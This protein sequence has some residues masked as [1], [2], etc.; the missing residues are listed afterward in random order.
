[1]RIKVTIAMCFVFCLFSFWGADWFG[2]LSYFIWAKSGGIEHVPME[3]F[4]LWLVDKVCTDYLQFRMIVWG[5]ALG[6]F[7]FTLKRLQLNLGVALFFFCSIYLITFSYARASLAMSLLFAGY[8]LLW[9]HN[10][11]AALKNR[12]IGLSLIGLS[13]FCHKSSVLGITAVVAAIIVKKWGRN[14]VILVLLAFPL[15]VF[16]M[17]FFL[18]DMFCRL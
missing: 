10:K 1:M 4:Y 16:A 17:Q 14:W 9:E 11:K 8:S 18:Q 2:Y 15:L 3:S 6:L 7:V 12:L 5:L 13:F